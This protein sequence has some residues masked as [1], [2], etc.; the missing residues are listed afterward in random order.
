MLQSVKSE[1]GS[2]G[3]PYHLVQL[4]GAIQTTD[5][6]SMRELARQLVRKGAIK[7]PK[8]GEEGALDLGLE[9]E[10]EEEGIPGLEETIEEDG[11]ENDEE[12]LAVTNA[13]LVSLQL[14]QQH[15][16]RALTDVCLSILLVLS[17]QHHQHDFNTAIHR[18]QFKESAAVDHHTRL[19]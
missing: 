12:K 7:V 19:L 13:V 2:E 16:N 3:Q 8:E 18:L 17:I 9:G 15:L 6:L 1:S 11:N 10:E 14:Q 4:D 5:R